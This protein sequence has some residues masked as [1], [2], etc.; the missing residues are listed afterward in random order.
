MLDDDELIERSREIRARVKDL[1]TWSEV[2]RETSRAI[3]EREIGRTRSV[4]PE[5][6]A[7]A[8][9]PTTRT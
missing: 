8:R 3:V 4:L 7:G 5:E 6:P 1:E 2:V 9:E